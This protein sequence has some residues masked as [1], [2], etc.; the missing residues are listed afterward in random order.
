MVERSIKKLTDREHILAR[1]SMYIGAISDTA[2]E[3]CL[4]NG[5]NKFTFTNVTYNP[6]LLKI[7]DEIL[8]NSVDEA[9]A[10]NF[11]YAN[12]INISFANN[13][14]SIEDNGRGLPQ[15]EIDGVPQ[16]VIAF[17]E[18]RAGSN[19]DETTKAKGIGMN[20]IGSYL[21]NCYSKSFIVE[22]SNG[23]NKI[24][25]TCKDNAE[26]HSHAISKSSKQG[27][28]VTFT[29]DL[30]KFGMTEIKSVYFELITNRCF[31]LAQSFPDIKFK[32]DFKGVS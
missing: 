32:L 10:T 29:P 8:D 20:G 26:T 24:T 30:E 31:H 13:T 19:F 28:K 9:I 15:G 22:T 16:A 1:A 11:K 25:L 18:A 21:T 27:T 12:T 17:T 23:V 6:G 4:M 2:K 14:F 7:F 5:D 3:M